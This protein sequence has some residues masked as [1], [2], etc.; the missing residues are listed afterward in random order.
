MKDKELKCNIKEPHSH[1][2]AGI[3]FACENGKKENKL[4]GSWWYGIARY[5][6][7]PNRKWWQFWRPKYIKV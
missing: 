1:L 3:T 5:V 6:K 2:V 4:K 7:N